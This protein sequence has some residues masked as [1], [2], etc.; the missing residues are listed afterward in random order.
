MKTDAKIFDG[1]DAE[2]LRNYL[3]FFL[4]HYRAM[5]AFWFLYLTEQFGQPA[6]EQINERV[7]G[8]VGGMAAKDLV[9]R[10]AIKEKGLRGFVEVLRYYPWSVLIGYEIEERADEVILSV[11]VC[12]VQEARRKRGLGEYACQAMHHA[13]FASIAQ[14]VDERICVACRFAPPDPH[15]PAMD[16][17]WRFTLNKKAAP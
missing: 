16:C 6:A 7:W 13:E 3:G 17:Q 9:E 2:A 10:F 12:P 11:P 8:K 15:P 14:A 1:M 5:D 4:R